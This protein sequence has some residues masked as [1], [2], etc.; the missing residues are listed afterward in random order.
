MR[1][2]TNGTT[3]Y[4][5]LKN[6]GPSPPLYDEEKPK[7]EPK[8]DDENEEEEEEEEQEEEDDENESSE[9]SSERPLTIGSLL[10]G[11]QPNSWTMSNYIEEKKNKSSASINLKLV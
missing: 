6:S 10:E 11:L 4:N 5:Y 9:Q 2:N 3:C 7:E 8:Q 1:R